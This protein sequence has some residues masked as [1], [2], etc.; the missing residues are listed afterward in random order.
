MAIGIDV[1]ISPDGAVSGG[2]VAETSLDKVG[3][4][5]D[6]TVRS[7]MT[8]R[9]EMNAMA[10]ASLATSRRQTEYQKTLVGST[11]A[12]HRLT[13]AT[14]VA[15]NSLG[16]F[17]GFVGQAGFQLSDIAIQLGAGANA[18]M[19]FGI[20]GGQLLGF[21]S[22]MAGA[23]ATV[24]GI[25]IGQFQ[26]GM[27]G[28]AD[29]TR[30]L[31]AALTRTN[32]Q[33]NEMSAAQARLAQAR[34]AEAL[35]Q[36]LT[37]LNRTRVELAIATEE[38]DK[39]RSRVEE[40]GGSQVIGKGLLLGFE[41]LVQSFS[42]SEENAK[43]LADRKEELEDR[44]DSNREALEKYNTVL[45][46]NTLSEENAAAVA[47]RRTDTI[48]N[49][50]ENLIVLQTRLSGNNREATIQEAVFRSGA[51]AGSAYA[52]QI[53]LLAGQQ[54]DLQQQLRAT[55]DA[56][57]EYDKDGEYLVRLQQQAELV[58]YSARQQAI[59]RAEYA[60]SAEAT[61]QQI[62]QARELAAAIYDQQ[63]AQ[64][65]PDT[66]DAEFESGITGQSRAIALAEENES[67]FE[68]LENQ[69]QMILLFQEEGIGDAQAHADAL[70][71][72]QKRT[73]KE[74]AGIVSS[75]LGSILALQEAWG[76]DSSG[77]YKA[78]AVVQK[79]AT[80]YSVL[81][82]SYDAIGKAWSSAP[83]PYNIPAVATATIE[84]GALQAAV[85]A[86]TPAFATGGM[87]YGPGTGT[88]DSFTA[89][90]SN[91]EFIMPA[92]QTRQYYGDLE[93]MRSGNYSRDG[94]GNMV[95]VN[96]INQT[97]GRVDSTS[98]EWVSR[99]ELNVILR[100]DVPGIVADE[101]NNEYSS[102]N[103]ALQN[104]YVMQRNL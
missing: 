64:R 38:V 61:Q 20:Q 13:Q 46:G 8:L 19:V 50:S 14:D 85:S 78:L 68:Q 15:G 16:K 27:Y 77:I 24:A 18:A 48:R 11:A 43:K 12:T 91:G 76:D 60:L 3:Q 90:I 94:G 40:I 89:R 28:A 52:Q 87:A 44:I 69:R 53:A 33:I 95:K 10:A 92:Q 84:T 26:G 6:K 67:I 56:V 101:V 81:L 57:K 63:Q 51:E 4:A 86:V 55:N 42:D 79:S 37:E 2:R 30:E 23:L 32:A 1:T 100:E 59:L 82:S 36:D 25:L 58:G 97:T 66:S 70:V 99:D 73:Y 17:Q 5:A 102:T 39:F 88:S 80:L 93:S 29:A 98:T 47:E 83:F 74:Q 35:S 104:Q 31:D 45:Q 62:D 71:A 96:V 65:G 75:G 7:T 22:P 72:I 54:Y 34:I 41:E 9:D 49:M 21:L 103:G